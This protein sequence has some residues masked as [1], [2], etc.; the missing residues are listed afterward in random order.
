MYLY[1]IIMIL[2]NVTRDKSTGNNYA[3]VGGD[4]NHI[5]GVFTGDKY[6]HNLFLVIFLIDNIIFYLIIFPF[7]SI[8]IDKILINTPLT[9]MTIYIFLLY[10]RMDEI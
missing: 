1:I 9:H 7:E 4:C 6:F 3:N 10:I 8:Y 2:S 5:S